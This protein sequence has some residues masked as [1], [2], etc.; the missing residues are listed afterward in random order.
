MTQLD[1]LPSETLAHILHCAADCGLPSLLALAGTSQRLHAIYTVHQLPLLHLALDASYGPLEDV[2]QLVTHNASQPAHLIRAAPLSFA[3]MNTI[4][5]VG[6]IA[7]RWEDIYPFKKWQGASSVHRRLLNAKERRSLRRAIYRIWLYSNAFHTPKFSRFTRRIPQIQILRAKL[8]YGW[9]VSDLA[10]I[11]DV[12]AILRKILAEN[13][14]PSNAR[15]QKKVEARYGEE[16]ANS[17]FFGSQAI[18]MVSQ[19]QTNGSTYYQ[20][21]PTRTDSRYVIGNYHD[22]AL[23]AYGDDIRYAPAPETYHMPHKLTR[24]PQ[25]LLPHRRHAQA[26][27]LPDPAP[28]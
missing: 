7:K 26:Q 8:L 20:H 2:I 5:D 11:M 13:V 14:C 9:T 16:F 3:L 27:S 4:I 12:Y 15:V 25:S 21:L 10:E 1:F 28:I 17:L 22:P 18:S 23:E 6:R 19:T 24:L